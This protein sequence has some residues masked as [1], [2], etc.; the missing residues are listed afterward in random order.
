MAFTV[1]P[2]HDRCKGGVVIH[3]IAALDS[4]DGY[5][6]RPFVCGCVKG[7]RIEAAQALI[8]N[9]RRET[10]PQ[11]TPEQRAARVVAAVL[12]L[13]DASEHAANMLAE[14]GPDWHL[15]LAAWERVEKAGAT[16]HRQSRLLAGKSKGG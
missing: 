6:D 15:T 3:R 8:R 9:P 7:D 2:L 12:E 1:D 13:A 5:I 16:V 4:P 14:H 11:I 10:M